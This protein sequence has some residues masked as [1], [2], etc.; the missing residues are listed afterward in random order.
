MASDTIRNSEEEKNLLLTKQHFDPVQS[1]E[2]DDDSPITVS[3]P[4]TT[5]N[6]DS[7]TTITKV[8]A[9]DDKEFTKLYND[10]LELDG[11]L[12]SFEPKHKDYVGKLEEVETLKTKYRTDFDKYK[13]KLDQ[14]QKDIKQLK[15]TYSKKGK[16]QCEERIRFP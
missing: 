6:T 3:P 13:K 12:R 10:W 4:S 5:N 8:E 7:P 1:E 15:A 14:L 11:E 2:D 9:F 16:N